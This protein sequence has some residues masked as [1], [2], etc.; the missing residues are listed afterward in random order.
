MSDSFHRMSVN[1]ELRQTGKVAVPKVSSG[2][3]VDT[4]KSQS[5]PVDKDMSQSFPMDTD[6]SQSFPMV[7]GNS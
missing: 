5:S 3:L 2:C 7:T 1:A 4:D 6:K